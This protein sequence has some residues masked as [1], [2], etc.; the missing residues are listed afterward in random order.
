MFFSLIGFFILAFIVLTLAN[1]IVTQML[2]DLDGFIRTTRDPS[3]WDAIFLSAYT[4]LLATAIAFISGVPLAYLLAREN[5][6]GKGLIEGIVDLPIVVPHTV[7]GIALLTVFGRYGLIG[8]FSLI[9]FT[10][11]IPGIVAAML[12]VSAPFLINSAREGF[13]SVDPRLENVARSL[14]ASRWETFCKITFPLAFR[15]LLTG[16]IMCWARAISEFGA[17]VVIAYYPMIAPTLIYER[18]I[19]GGLPA[20]RPI[21]VLLI[22]FCLMIFVMLRILARKR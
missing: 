17:V 14:G 21:A 19:S 4:A 9:R 5:F 2:L 20:S 12:F 18:Y 10:D 22:I 15:H 3:V 6:I 8:Q 1:T 16:A 11:A 7:A 13:K